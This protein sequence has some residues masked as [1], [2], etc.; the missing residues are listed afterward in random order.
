MLTLVFLCSLWSIGEFADSTV[1][2]FVTSNLVSIRHIAFIINIHRQ[3]EGS[4]FEWHCYYKNYPCRPIKMC[5]KWVVAGLWTPLIQLF[6]VVFSVLKEQHLKPDRHRPLSCWLFI[7]ASA[8][9]GKRKDL[10]VTTAFY[11]WKKK[12]LPNC[13]Q[14]LLSRPQEQVA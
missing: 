2:I 3:L 7:W 9:L 4:S 13:T 5:F 1:W 10:L 8:M 11:D 6:S 14:P 12:I